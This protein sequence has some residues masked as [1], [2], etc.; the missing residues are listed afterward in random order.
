MRKDLCKEIVEK[1]REYGKNSDKYIIEELNKSIFNFHQWVDRKRI[2]GIF[3]VND[4]N[5]NE[6]YHFIFIDWQCNYKNYYL[7]IYPE[8]K[9]GPLVEIHKVDEVCGNLDFTWRYSPTK[10]DGKNTDRREYFEKYYGTLET[11][12]KV[13]SKNDEV[14]AFIDD[15]IELVIKRC[16]ADLLDEQIPDKREEFPEGRT[17]EVIHRKRERNT[18]LINIVK[19]D[20]KA[21]SGELTCEV[22]GFNFKAAYGSIGE[23]FIEAHHTIPVSELNEDSITSI[24]DIALVCSNCHSMLHRK[25]PWLKM[26]ELKA[27]L[28]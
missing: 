28:K 3:L 11:R 4:L 22:C 13:P 26:N 16:K 7:V 9:V 25:R 15:V 1:V 20:R 17:Y 8:N 19:S 21:Q 2:L 23:D 5:S 27:L 10:R 6:K 24:E 18:K 12:I 14:Q